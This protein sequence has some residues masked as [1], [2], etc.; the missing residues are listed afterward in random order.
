MTDKEPTV[1][2]YIKA[3]LMPWKGP[4]PEIPPGK[5]SEPDGV[6]VIAEQRA[7]SEPALSGGAI[8]AAS[9]SEAASFAAL[10]SGGALDQDAYGEIDLFTRREPLESDAQSSVSA[11]SLPWRSLVVLGLALFAQNA[12]APPDRA[13]SAGVIGYLL[14]AG[15]VAWAVWRGEWPLAALP[16]VEPVRDPL[17]VRQVSLWVGVLLMPVSFLTLGGN[18]FTGFNF[19]LL[20]LVIALLVYGL[21]LPDRSSP[22]LFRRLTQF[23]SLG[24][25]RIVIDRRTLIVLGAIA[26]VLF[27]RFYKLADVPPEMTSDHAEKLLDISDVLNGQTHI[28]FPRNAGREA[29]IFYLNAI[30]ATWVGTGLS[31]ITLKISTALIGLMV[32]PIIYLLGREIASA[33]V[34]LWAAVLAGIAYWPNVISRVGLRFPFYP[35]FTATTFYFLIRGFRRNSRNDYLLAGL[36]LGL[37]LYG[38]TA[39]RIL[40]LVVVAAFGIFLLHRQSAG[41]R[42]QSIWLFCMLVLLSIAV[43]LPMMRFLLDD[44]DAIAFRAMTRMGTLERPLPGPAWQI[45][46]SNLWNALKMFS[47]EDGNVWLA[48]VSYIPALGVVTGALFHVGI[49]L[50][51]I[52]YLRRRNWLDLFLLVSIPLL[53]LPSILALAFPIENPNLYRTGGALVPVFLI[54][55]FTL[56][57][58]LT[59]LRDR[60]GSVWGIRAAWMVGGFLLLW[61]GFQNYNLV[62]ERYFMEYRLSAWNTTELGEV[63]RSFADSVGTEDSAWVV[64]YPYWV[65]TRLVGIDAGV[66]IKDYALWPDQ[67][68]QSLPVAPPKLFLVKPDDLEGQQVLV[69]LYPNGWFTRYNSFIEDKDFLIYFVPVEN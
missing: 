33:R 27:F 39:D 36:S 44:P 23:V 14:A 37:S 69:S 41:R 68:D 38:Y 4:A 55:A 6:K 45:F 54:V 63:I 7:E 25:W 10:Q 20:L 18:L 42:G 35:L 3:R 34:G 58:F 59:I 21:W 64:P 19:A 28:F 8:R 66:P 62:F 2:D 31:F 29:L 22:S 9:P 60:L 11:R 5:A 49:V 1:L 15:W 48:S 13:V 16:E 43:F 67:L 30:I 51:F 40:P 46:L 61:A 50:V 17:A 47:W 56:D 12:L 26:L 65:D 53:M 24:R 32:L 57:G 52:R